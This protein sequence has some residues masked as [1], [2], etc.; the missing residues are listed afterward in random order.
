MA[1]PPAHLRPMLAT[2]GPLPASSE[3]EAFTFEFKWDGIRAVLHWDGSS[4]R[5]ETRN[6]REVTVA[7]PELAAMG[8]VLGSRPVVLD[9]EIVAFD[10]HGVPSFQRLQER[11][12]VGDPRTAADKAGRVPACW[13]AFDVLHL[14]DRST[15]ALP[16]SERRPILESLALAGPSWAT[17]PSFPG[18]GDDTLAAARSRG[19][20]GVV[21][22]RVSSTYVPGARSR[23]WV[24]VK[25]VARDEFVVGGWL[26]GEG[27]R[28]GRIGSLLLGLPDGQGLLAYVGAV[29]TGFTDADLA[30][31][32]RELAGDVTS[33]SPFS[34][35]LPRRDAVFVEPRLVV[36][37]EY[38]QRTDAG[39]LRHPSYKGTRVD[40]SPADL[41]DGGDEVPRPA[42]PQSGDGPGGGGSSS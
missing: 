22:K 34:T 35:T 42:A 41:A 32:T 29:G 37:V 33:A 19:M 38:R 25:L 3:Q 17:P 26:P 1:P 28:G 8:A 23:D 11:M 20:E 5:V 14:G 18:A 10:D 9:G 12:H 13:L 15:L 6:L 2:A 21:A 36:D 27:H 24:K 7:Y 39:I 30:R 31:L 16:W 40:K 4:M